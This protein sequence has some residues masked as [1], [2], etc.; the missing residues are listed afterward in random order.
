[1]TF[2]ADQIVLDFQHAVSAMVQTEEGRPI[3]GALFGLVRVLCMVLLAMLYD[4]VRNV[5]PF[6]LVDHFGVS[7]DFPFDVFVAGTIGWSNG[8]PE[9][10]VDQPWYSHSIPVYLYTSIQVYLYT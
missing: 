6:P 1:M 5:V 9:N 3:Y 7:P 8:G 2:Y 10:I 4:V